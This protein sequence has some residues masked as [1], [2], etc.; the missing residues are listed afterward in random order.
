MKYGVGE[1]IQLTRMILFASNDYILPGSY[2]KI[3]ATPDEHCLSYRILTSNGMV[4]LVSEDMIVGV[5]E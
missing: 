3:I 2:I 4:K 1:V 5:S